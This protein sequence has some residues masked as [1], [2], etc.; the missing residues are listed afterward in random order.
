MRCFLP[1]LLLSLL[2]A[3]Q[4]ASTAGSRLLVVLEETAD[5]GLYS[6]FWA[7]LEGEHGNW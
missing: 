4:A 7:D 6:K 2:A 3:V 1:L 5:K